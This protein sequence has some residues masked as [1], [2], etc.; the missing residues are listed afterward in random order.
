MHNYAKLDAII[1][2]LCGI[3][4]FTVGLS[5]QEIIGFESRFYLFAL[6]MLRHGVSWF[7]TTYRHPYPDYPVTSTLLIYLSAKLFGGLT[8]FTAVLPSAVAAA[9]TLS[10]TYLIGATH[11]R[12]LGW[13][14][15]GFLLFTLTFLM[16][17]RTISLDMFVTAFTAFAFY[18]A[19]TAHVQQK[20]LP[21]VW[22]MILL[23]MSFAVRGPIGLVIPTAVLCVFYL[24]EKEIKTFFLVGTLAAVLLVLCTLL[25]LGIAYHAGGDDLLQ[26]VLRMEVLGR[27]QGVAPPVYFYWLEGLSAYAVTYPLAILV[28]LMAAWRRDEQFKV[29]K[30]LAAWGFILLIGLS[31]PADKKMR[32]I[33]PMAPA[34]ALICAHIFRRKNMFRTIVFVSAVTAWVLTYILIVEPANLRANLTRDF[35]QRIEALRELH[36]ARLV[37]YH[38]GPDGLVIKYLV[39]MPKEEDPIFITDFQQLNHIKQPVFVITQEDNLRV[40]PP[41]SLHIIARGKVGHDAVLVFSKGELLPVGGF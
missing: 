20:K 12:R 25:L 39:S 32:Y 26:A 17:A 16:E 23:G 30:I 22:I 1:V 7:P 38:E 2:F 36:H 35:V 18:F 5:H 3:V 21:L 6:E 14:A 9:A 8:K 29:I 34:L 40:I 13:F 37:F 27:L 15:V 28:F 11:V 31:V 24:M 4:L 19:Y 10:A 41:R 33:L